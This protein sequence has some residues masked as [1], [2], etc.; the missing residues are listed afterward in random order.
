LELEISIENSEQESVDK[1]ETLRDVNFSDQQWIE[2][3][4]S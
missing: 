4:K 1:E 3:I 2:Y